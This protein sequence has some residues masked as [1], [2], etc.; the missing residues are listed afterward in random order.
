MAE[1]QR[2]ATIRMPG[3]L[4]SESGYGAWGSLVHSAEGHDEMRCFNN[5]ALSQVTSSLDELGSLASNVFMLNL[6]HATSTAG[7]IFLLERQRIRASRSLST[8]GNMDPK[9][10]HRLSFHGRC[11]ACMQSSLRR[12]AM[13][14][15]QQITSLHSVPLEP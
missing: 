14:F 10:D 11:Q 2:Q 5:L 9:P 15:E 4:L 13:P 1:Q 7:D 12:D 8:G 3:N 6:F